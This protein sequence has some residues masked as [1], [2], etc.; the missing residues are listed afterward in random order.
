[1][2]SRLAQSVESVPAW[3]DGLALKLVRSNRPDGFEMADDLEVL[4]RGSEMRE[5]DRTR[6]ADWGPLKIRVEEAN[7]SDLAREL[8][9]NCFFHPEWLRTHAPI[10]CDDARC[11]AC[12]AADGYDAPDAPFCLGIHVVLN[13]E[14]WYS[15][16][17]CANC[18][19]RLK[20]ELG[21]HP[22]SGRSAP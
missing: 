7:R 10:G 5:I 12:G 9:T 18:H 20:A 17:L 1:M 4:R 8:Y 21:P 6:P 13:D 11:I 14:Q 3:R 15:A 19:S 2:E 16:T 22:S